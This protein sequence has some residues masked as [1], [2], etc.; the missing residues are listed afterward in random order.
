MPR[1]A[2][3]FSA[4]HVYH[5]YNRGVNRAN[6]FSTAENYCYLLRQ[7][8]DVLTAVPATMFA[9]CLM[10]NHY[11]FVIRQDDDIPL[12][13]FIGRLFKRYTQAY[14]RQQKRTGPLFAGR[15]RCIHVDT[16]EYLI[17]LARY[18]H[19]NPVVAGLCRVP[20]QWPYS[21]YLEWIEQRDGTLVDRDWV[22]QYFPT[23]ESY[24]KFVQSEVSSQMEERLKPYL[25]EED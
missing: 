12:S 7:V 1:R 19:L 18:V 5:L 15:F 4:N 16:D 11:H 6:I 13:E 24:I 17:H 21:N 14:N 2:E 10:P 8:K 9:Y 23:A 25:L 22:R 3:V 20:E